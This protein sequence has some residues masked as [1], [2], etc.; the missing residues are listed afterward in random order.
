MLKKS[1]YKK[2]YLLAVLRIR[3]VYPGS[4]F[5]HPGS[6]SKNL[7]ILTPGKLKNGFQAL[8]YMIRVVHPGSGC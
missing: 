8:E 2:Y 1:T 6:A 4:D 5:F 7:S 3:D